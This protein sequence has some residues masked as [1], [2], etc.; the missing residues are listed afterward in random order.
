VNV[1][2]EP[3]DDVATVPARKQLR[4]RQKLLHLTCDEH[5]RG[6]A[7]RRTRRS[8]GWYRTKPVEVA[9][10]RSRLSKLRR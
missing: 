7:L 1:S 6:F 3:V 4:A 8:C 9:M 2:D 5:L 10:I